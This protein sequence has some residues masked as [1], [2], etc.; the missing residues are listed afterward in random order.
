[1][2]A[3][4]I[5]N[6]VWQYVNGEV[7]KPVTP[8]KQNH[9]RKNEAEWMQKD[10]KAKSDIILSIKPSKLKQIEECQTSHEIWL[11][12][13]KTYTS[14]RLAQRTLLK[15][16]KLQRM[17]DRDDVREHVQEFLNIV[18]KL[19]EKNI[20]INPEFLAIMLL[21]SLPSSFDNFRRDIELYD[22]L[23]S[24]ESLKKKIMDEGKH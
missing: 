3:V 16:L 10:N 18:D 14:K 12:L 20:E 21:Y 17:E 19:A 4:L 7:R 8:G 24:L 2:K 6:D 23:P 22:E 1:M 11:K 13:E 15:Q 5:K 9:L